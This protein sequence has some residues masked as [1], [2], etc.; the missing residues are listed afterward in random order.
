MNNVLCEAIVAL[1]REERFY[2]EL[3]TQM[4]RVESYSTDTLGVCIKG[5][6]QLVYNPDF[7]KSKSLNEQVALLKHECQHILNDHIGRSKELA[8]EVYDKKDK[9]V[10]DRVISTQKH[11]AINI[12]CD[13]AINVGIP[14]IP[15]DSLFPSTFGLPDNHTMEWYLHNLKDN[16]KM[17][18]VNEYDDHSIWSESEGSK[19]EMREKL[20]AAINKACTNARA[21]GS[22]SA[23]HELL[24]E[25]FNFKPRDWRTDLRRFVANS[26][27]IKLESSRKK[28]NRR[29]GITYPGFIKEEQLHIGVAIDTSGSVSDEALGQFMAE[30]GNIS[31]YAK[32]TIVQ[33]DSEVKSACTYDPKKKC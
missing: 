20:K 18:G 21:A 24:V 6:V 4:D 16:E 28:R 10:I 9:D 32:I 19:E 17:K 2:A 7:F 25:R 3:I 31:K 5:P 33:A 14:N 11:K 8:P 26:M 12:A 27:E 22:M 30:V 1:F 23:E 13:C 15:K 29:Y